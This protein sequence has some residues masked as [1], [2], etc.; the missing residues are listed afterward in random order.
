MGIVEKPPHPTRAFIEAWL[1]ERD[2]AA[3]R[4]RICIDSTA[5]A[6]AA[7]GVVIAIA[8]LIVAVVALQC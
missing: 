2:A 7:I 4:Y 8:G 3:R 5:L 1:G 6:L